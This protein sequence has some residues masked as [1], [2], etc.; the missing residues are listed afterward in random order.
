MMDRMVN[1]GI[2][3]PQLV[4]EMAIEVPLSTA[5]SV[6]TTNLMSFA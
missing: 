2:D 6:N 5:I 1:I 4:P 3:F